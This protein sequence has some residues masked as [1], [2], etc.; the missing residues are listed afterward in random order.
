MQIRTRIEKCEGNECLAGADDQANE[1]AAP[2]QS[3]DRQ[4]P[5][6]IR[7]SAARC[8]EQHAL[9]TFELLPAN[10]HVHVSLENR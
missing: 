6:Q 2:E 7:R 3:N 4:Q 5:R 8:A 1:A 9:P 10:R